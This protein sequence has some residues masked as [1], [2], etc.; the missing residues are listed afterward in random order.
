M[1]ERVIGTLVSAAMSRRGFAFFAWLPLKVAVFARQTSGFISVLLHAE[2]I[3]MLRLR[4]IMTEDVATLSPE[5]TLGEAMALFSSR[6]I[7]GAPVLASGQ[8]VGVV[9]LSDMADF[10]ATSPGV[11][12]ERPEHAEW[13]E[14]GE[15]DEER[16]LPEGAEP[17]STFFAQLWDDAGADVAERILE[18]RGPEWN[19]LE[20]HMVG[21]VMSRQIRALAPETSVEYAAA[22]L[23]TH[24]IHRVLVMD[25]A[26]LV[27]VVST[28]DISNAVA[29]HRISSV[30]FVF[31]STKP[32]MTS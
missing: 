20:E 26:Q 5:H 21:E 28:T 4:D 31:A 1:W 14:W 3:S 11:P 18:T 2:V 27:G 6:H 12:T 17:P 13:G 22:F 16:E 15:W 23:R 7:S 9:T 32:E 25:E 8:V 30:Q 24:S 29:D 19:T 10:V